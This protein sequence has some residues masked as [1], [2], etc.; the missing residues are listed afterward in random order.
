M[1]DRTLLGNRENL[2]VFSIHDQLIENMICS[3]NSLRIRPTVSMKFNNVMIPNCLYDCGSECSLIN[4]STLEHIQMNSSIPLKEVP[5]KIKA[6]AANKSSLTVSQCFEMICEFDGLKTKEYILVCDDINDK[7]IIG[8][9]LIRRLQLAYDPVTNL[10][11]RR[12]ACRFSMKTKNKVSIQPYKIAYVKV[13]VRNDF[14]ENCTKNTILAQIHP[15]NCPTLV[16]CNELVETNEV[17]VATICIF[18]SGHQ[19]ISLSKNHVMGGAEI[20]DPLHIRKVEEIL[21]EAIISSI[22]TIT[23]KIKNKSTKQLA[24]S[25][26]D[27]VWIRNN[28]KLDHLSKEEQELFYEVLFEF[29]YV[30]SRHKYDIGKVD[31]KL[32]EHTIED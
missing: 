20:I 25:E 19:T 6:S 7:C 30:F 8:I 14:E 32:F 31:P 24:P 9:P 4:K 23:T 3:I 28:I 10:V 22:N 2:A 1:K 16:S 13:A 18:N 27:K 11:S 17:G 29:H 15:E 12:S 21:P 5:I 26:E